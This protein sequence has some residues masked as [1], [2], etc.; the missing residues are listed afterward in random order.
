MKFYE[1][2]ANSNHTFLYANYT[3][4]LQLLNYNLRKLYFIMLV[5]ILVCDDSSYS[6]LL[7]LCFSKK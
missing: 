4:F 5:F 2:H 3:I 6:L 1:Q 7:N